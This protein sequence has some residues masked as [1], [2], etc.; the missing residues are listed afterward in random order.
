MTVPT[1]LAALLLERT[2]AEG[3]AFTPSLAPAAPAR[4]SLTVNVDRVTPG[5]RVMFM[6]AAVTVRALLGR[7][8]GPNPKRVVL[9]ED[10]AGAFEVEQLEALPFTLA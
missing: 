9:L 10:E 4:R 8:G 5:Q 2:E 3:F 7:V 6:G 1:A